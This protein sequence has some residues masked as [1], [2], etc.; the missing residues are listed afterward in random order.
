MKALKK[1]FLKGNVV[2]DYG[3]LNDVDTTALRNAVDALTDAEKRGQ[4]I[5]AVRAGE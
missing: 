5:V 4:R 3:R 2:L 1:H